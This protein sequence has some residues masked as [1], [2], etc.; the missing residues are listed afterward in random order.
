MKLKGLEGLW[1]ETELKGIQKALLT[2]IQNK[3]ITVPDATR[4]RK[5]EI[6]IVFLING[7]EDYRS[8]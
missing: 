1:E 5:G 4:E 7:G 3:M 2:T 8:S 6:A